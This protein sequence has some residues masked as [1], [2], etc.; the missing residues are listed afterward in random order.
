MEGKGSSYIVENRHS[1]QA[2]WQLNT[3][4]NM[5]LTDQLALQGGAGANYARSSYYKTIKDLLGGTHWSDFDQ[6][7]E[8]DFPDNP[9]MAQNDLNNPNRKVGV[10]D[11]FGYDYNINQVGAN[12]W[13]Q[14]SWTFAKWDLA[15]GATGSFT[16]YQREGFM[17]NGRAPENSFGKGATH[18]FFNYGAKASV[19]YKIDGRNSFVAHGYYGTRAPLSYNAYVSPRIKDDVITNLN[20]EIIASGDISYEW[21]YRNFKGVVTG[22]YT[23]MR[24]G[25]ERT[26]FYDDLAST[27][28]NYALT[29]VHKVFKGV[30]VGLSYKL[31]SSLTVSAAANIGRYQYKNRPT[32]TRS[33]ENGSQ[34]D[35][36][37]TVYLKNYYVSGTP[38]EAYSLAFKYAGPHM[39][40]FELNGAWMNRAY[41]DLSPVRHEA[42]PD[43][44]KVCSSEA[45]LEQ[46][47]REISTQDKFNEALVIN[48]SLGK[49]IYLSRSASLNLNLSIN[50]LLDNRN[51][52]TGGY[53]QGRFD[54]KNFSTTK[55]PNKYYYAQ[56]I[57]IFVNAGVRF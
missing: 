51:I 20:S 16:Q 6:F 27:F 28:M 33:Y 29:N 24:K 47:L 9:D 1:N 53:Q 49:L 4:L 30:E 22:F 31:T 3:N 54:Y 52:Q 36:T 40:F 56:G 23:D 7:A 48:M 18:T 50:N 46:R 17:R 13:L 32:G 15:Y 44:W 57:R 2:S 42:L 11:R 37:Q 55:Y 35:V 25:T 26:A 38:Q 8:R 41:V 39:W 5:R 34:P 10:D 19:M 21:N 45:E 14:N 12:L 43:L